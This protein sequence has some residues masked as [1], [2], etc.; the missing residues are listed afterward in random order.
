MAIDL[1]RS[2]TI[3]MLPIDT[4][5][6][7]HFN[8]YTFNSWNKYL[9]IYINIIIQNNQYFIKLNNNIIN[10]NLI[11]NKIID[12]NDFSDYFKIKDMIY[13]N[14]VSFNLKLKLLVLKVFKY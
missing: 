6:K 12:I 1:I 3:K 5:L 8:R 13:H 14:Y 7:V 11:D 2:Q 9:D 10:Y 4:I